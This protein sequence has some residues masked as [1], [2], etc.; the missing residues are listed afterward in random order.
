V[1]RALRT[2]ELV[3]A[4][5]RQRVVDAVAKTGYVVNSIASSLR[6]GRSSIVTVFVASLRNPHFASA[7]QGAIDAFE[8]S[9]FRLM[10]A[11]TGYSEQL[12]PDVVEMLLPFRPAGVMFT[13]VI[14]NERTRTALRNLGVPVVEMWGDRP[15]PI[16][17]LVGSSGYHGGR[18]MGEHFGERGF[19]RIAYSGHTQERGNERFEGFRDGLKTHGLEPAL[20]VPKQGTRGFAEGMEALDEILD[21]L[22]DC[23][24]VFFGT[25]L[26]AVGAIIAARRRGIDLPERLALAGYGD[27]DFAAQVEPAITSIHVSDYDIGRL[28]GDMMLKRLNG[29]TVNELIIQVP[30]HLEARH[31]TARG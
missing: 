5:T 2:P 24:A 9:R 17:M 16:D 27:L 25:D 1:S 19:R 23:D 11:Q 22:P 4:E 28:A 26:L 13:G 10:F 20:I 6:S 15:D 18:L 30:V 8:G 7:M 12:N 29:D 14:R 21:R 31:S 3:R